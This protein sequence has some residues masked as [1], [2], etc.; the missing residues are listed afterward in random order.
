M[1]L[2]IPDRSAISVDCRASEFQVKPPNVAGRGL[3]SLQGSKGQVL[4][5][6]TAQ[7]SHFFFN[8]LIN[9]AMHTDH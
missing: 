8:S 3:V 6:P 5:L 4:N 2:T 1:R 9:F 7:A